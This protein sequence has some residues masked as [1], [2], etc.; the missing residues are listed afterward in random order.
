ME[1]GAE[2]WRR[3]LLEKGSVNG[4]ISSVNIDALN[5]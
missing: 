2:R 3:H 1:A 4:T 5:K